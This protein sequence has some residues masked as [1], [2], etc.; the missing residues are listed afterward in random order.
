MNSHG[1]PVDLADLAD[2]VRRTAEAEAGRHEGLVVAAVRGGERA[3]HGTGSTGAAG[4]T[5]DGDTLF[6]IGSV[7]K[8][9]TSLLLATA[10]ARGELALDTPVDG[11]LPELPTPASQPPITLAHLAGHSS[12]LPRLPPGVL[13]RGLRQWS[14]PYRGFGVD[15]LVAGYGRVR[16]RARP[17][18]RVRY[19]NFGAALLGQALARHAGTSWERLVAD[20]ITGPLGLH[21]TVPDPRADQQDRR[22][23][24]HSRRR[25]PVPDWDLAAVAPGGGLWSSANDVLT[26]LGAHLEPGTGPVPDALRLVQQPRFRATRWLQVCLG[27]ML[28]PLRGSRHSVLWHNGATGGFSS[29]AGFQPEL[30]VG[31]VVLTNT[32]RSVDRAGMALLT[33]LVNGAGTP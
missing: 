21:D 14:D 23:T 15:D 8:V 29:F 3:V 32:A 19:S 13:L 20:E 10:V 28:T 25:R 31:V 7:T 5:P 24:G 4:T 11:L 6:Q 12:G 33:D 16:P 30:G 9:F 2:L 17:G 22:A 1:D 27:W 18:R 26:F